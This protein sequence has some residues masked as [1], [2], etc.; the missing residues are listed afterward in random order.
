MPS[1]LKSPAAKPC[2]LLP[3]AIGEPAAV[4]VCCP[5]VPAPNGDVPS[6]Q[7]LLDVSR[8]DTFPPGDRLGLPTPTMVVVSDQLPAEPPV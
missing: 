5:N 7:L 3:T 8:R 1:L 4:T 2:G 6:G